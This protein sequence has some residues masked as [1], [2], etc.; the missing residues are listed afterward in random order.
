MRRLLILVLVAVLPICSVAG[1]LEEVKTYDDSGQ[2]IDIG[3]G[4]EFVIALGSNQ[5]TGY[6][7]QASYDETMLELIGGQST[8]EL[9]EEE[10]VGAGGIEYFRFKALEEGETTIN[11]VYKRPFEEEIIDQKVFT[12]NID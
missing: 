1:C 2:T 8:Y 10:L 3:V 5:S 12:V 7:W 6:S 11:L 9:S 4:Q